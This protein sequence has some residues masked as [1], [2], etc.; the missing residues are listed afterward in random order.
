MHRHALALVVLAAAALPAVVAGQAS[1][2]NPASLKE[3]APAT[4]K[5]EFD[6]S[7][8][9]FVV[10]V[11]R[12]WAPIAADRFYNMVKNGFYD[13]CRFFRVVPGF[14]VQ[15]G[16]NGDPA[17]TSAWSAASMKDEPTKQ[18]N[19]RGYLTFARTGA[20][21]SR[22]TQLFINYKDNA[23]L[24]QQGFA[25]F[26]EVTAGMDLVDKINAQYAEQPNQ[27]L[28]TQQGNAYLTKSFPKLDYIKK[29]TIGK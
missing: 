12:D 14:M 4:Y 27:G 13:D 18:S 9:K 15:F 25:P 16:M 26:G 19:K 3:T 24:D 5:A 1:L 17:V 11:H 2:K 8:G 7:A 6:T 28:I 23:F 22:G 29:A 10:D 20:P 21:N